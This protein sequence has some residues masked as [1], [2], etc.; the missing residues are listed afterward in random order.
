MQIVLIQAKSCNKKISTFVRFLMN[1][2][3]YISQR[4][5]NIPLIEIEVL[6]IIMK[7]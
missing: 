7:K 6:G 4:N 2:K 5:F 1:E 3:Q